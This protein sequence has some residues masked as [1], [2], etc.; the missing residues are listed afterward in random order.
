MLK[1]TPLLKH[2]GQKLPHSKEILSVCK[3]LKNMSLPLFPSPSVDYLVT[4]Q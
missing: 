3:Q 1:E 2:R 4:Y